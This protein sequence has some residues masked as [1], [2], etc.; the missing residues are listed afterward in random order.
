MVLMSARGVCAH[1]YV[2]APGWLVGFWQG[3]GT[4]LGPTLPKQ[5]G[6]GDKLWHVHTL[7]HI[8]AHRAAA[9]SAAAAVAQPRTPCS[10][11][12]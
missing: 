9:P 7:T 3:C 12:G 6:G 11:G 5:P 1:V 10:K 4:L 8:H 2:C